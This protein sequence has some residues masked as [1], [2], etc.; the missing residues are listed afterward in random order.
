MKTLFCALLLL[1]I[2][3]PAAPIYAADGCADGTTGNDT[4]TCSVTP[5]AAGN[6]DDQ[7]DGDMG[8]D[9][10]VQEAGVIT[11]NIDGDG[12]ISGDL[13]GLGDGGDDTIT[14]YG[15]VTAS[16]AGDWVSGGGGDD[17]IYN[18][19]QVNVNIMGDEV[20]G[21]GGSDTIVNAATVE[22]AIHGD[23]GDDTIILTDGSNGGADHLLLLDGG[24]G[25]DVLIF[26]FSD[27]AVH[28][29]VEAALA[30]QSAAEG[31]ITVD[32]ETYTWTDFEEIRNEAPSA[33]AVNRIRTGAPTRWSRFAIEL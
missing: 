5:P 15:T 14:N 32:G 4:L 29:Q 27:S 13:R 18:Y 12:A 22:N 20:L 31:S 33:S 2:L 3:I 6:A 21:E 28:D 1:M 23:G 10:M 17:I 7:F 9:V 19:G 16:I 30:G 11:V 8:D 24:A 26:S 25:T